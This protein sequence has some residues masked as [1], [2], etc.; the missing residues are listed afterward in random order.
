[1]I[2]HAVV[3]GASSGIGRQTALDLAA[4]GWH[5]VLVSRR[6]DVLNVVRAECL[7]AGATSAS[8]FAH[9][10]TR[11]DTRLLT[12]FVSATFHAPF[13]LVNAAGGATFG[14]FMTAADADLIQQVE[15]NLIGTMLMCHALLPPM[16]DFGGGHIVNV[17]SVCSKQAF[18][19]TA[20]YG[21][22]KAGA[23]MFTNCLNLEVRKKGIRVSA[24]MPGAVDTPLWQGKG[25]APEKEDMLPASAVSSVIVDILQSPADRSYDE[26]FLMPPKGIL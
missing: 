17:L 26:V 2:R 7:D 23:L 18:T 21:A 24:L 12:Q 14:D 3:S 5:L 9:D 6:E 19:G 16:I 22:A 15:L 11:R 13:A 10:I 1:M 4:A 25:W 8:V 20:A